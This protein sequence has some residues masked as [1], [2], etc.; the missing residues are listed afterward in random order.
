MFFGTH[1]KAVY[2]WYELMLKYC[3]YSQ[4]Q[5]G[6]GNNLCCCAK[7]FA[8]HNKTS[9]SNHIVFF[10]DENFFKSGSKDKLPE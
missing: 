9:Q 3:H 7:S 1:W 5:V 2:L 10:F 6:K 4:K 8:R